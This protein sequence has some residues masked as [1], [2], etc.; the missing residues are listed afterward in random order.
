MHIAP[1]NHRPVLLIICDHYLPGFKAGGPIVSIAAIIRLLANYTRIIVIT[2][3]RDYGDS[4]PYPSVLVNQ[5]TKAGDV[6][7]FYLSSKIKLLRAVTTSKPD[8]IYFNSLFSP[9]SLIALMSSLVFG[10]NL[11]RI[12]APR[13]ELGQGA[14]G[15]KPIKKRIY[16]T[17][18]RFLG[19]HKLLKFHATSDEEVSDILR[20]LRTNA[21][22]VSN[23]PSPEP[24]YIH[25]RTKL[26]GEGKFLY[27]SRVT[28][29]KNLHLA[30][31]A[32]KEIGNFKIEFDIYG[33]REDEDYWE[34]CMRIVDALPRN[35]QVRYLGPIMP[36]EV[37]N[38]FSAYH[39]LLMPTSNENFGH[40]IA[41]AL[42]NGVLPV[43]S[44]RTPWRNLEAIG[45]GW[46]VS[47]NEPANLVRAI[48][49]VIDLD[50]VEFELMSV[51]ASRY[52]GQLF[53]VKV[54]AEDY[55]RLFGIDSCVE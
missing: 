53:D 36:N 32:L 37:S 14:L 11:K 21:I 46:D 22:M 20:E 47:L 52:V 41:E 3:D 30:L 9:F 18:F 15:I 54:L 19:I 51:R 8:I 2:K 24:A 42:Q 6:E 35:V 29:K 17:L 16:L 44:D 27:I 31:E 5:A 1:K 34:T 26:R 39:A 49:Q 50:Q 7:V 43:I 12:L 23:V 40:A 13:G 4:H 28:R 33:P 48:K 10:R 55:R 38:I 25:L 45:I